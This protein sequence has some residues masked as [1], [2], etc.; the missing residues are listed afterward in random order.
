MELS[1]LTN[2]IMPLSTAVIMLGMGLSLRTIDFKRI[3]VAPLPIIIG[4]IGQIILLPL[5]GYSLAVLFALPAAHAVGLMILV[6]CAGGAASNLIVY[7]AKA[8]VALSVS[9]TALSSLITIMT[10]PLVVNFA[11]REFIQIDNVTQLPLGTTNLKLFVITVI[12]MLVGM[13][14]LHRYPNKARLWELWISRFTYVFVTILLAFVFVQ[15]N[16]IIFNHY[17]VIGISAYLLNVIT[18]GS[19]FLLATLAR[20]NMKQKLSISIEIGVQNGF[21]AIFIA[22]TLLGDT[23]Y[24]VFPAFYGV[25]M[26]IN[27]LLMLMVF[28]K[29]KRMS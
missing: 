7:L 21:M 12:P 9:L 20:L 1:I 2:L 15:N 6:A 28:N 18:M 24:V 13:F 8:D 19:G 17:D 5:V 29:K 22:V 14:L 3:F 11:L 27:V 23:S 26:Y 10:I 4:L 16:Q 25:I